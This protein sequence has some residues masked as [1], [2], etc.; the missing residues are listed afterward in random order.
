MTLTRSTTTRTAARKQQAL[1]SIAKP[2]QS[3]SYSPTG[4][5]GRDMITAFR[6]NDEIKRL[7]KQLEPFRQKFL[8]HCQK[9]KL[10]DMKIGDRR[11][12]RKARSRWTYSPELHNELL[13]L[14]WRQKQEQLNGI[15]V[16]NP[17]EYVSFT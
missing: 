14:Q 10:A 15:A 2:A 5:I 8:I 13:Q 6:I 11:I 16:N 3:R 4:D 17:T 1:Q 9:N 12:V 7:E